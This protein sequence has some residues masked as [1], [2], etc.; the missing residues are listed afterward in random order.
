MYKISLRH[1]VRMTNKE[2]IKVK[3]ICVKNTEAN[4]KGPKGPKMGVGGVIS[5]SKK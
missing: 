1:L 3:W 5:V 4:L 2:A